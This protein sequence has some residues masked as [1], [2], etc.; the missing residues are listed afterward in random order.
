MM[1]DV[2]QSFVEI[3][4]LTG[5]SKGRNSPAAKG[6]SQAER[7]WL[8]N[9]FGL[10]SW[11]ETRENIWS[12]RQEARVIDATLTWEKRPWASDGDFMRRCNGGE[13][14]EEG[15][16]QAAKYLNSGNETEIGIYENGRNRKI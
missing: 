16:K 1:L 2:Q 15:Q 7:A 14:G 13:K 11:M 4:R 9:W 5:R 10:N 3:P 8:E 6:L 12:E